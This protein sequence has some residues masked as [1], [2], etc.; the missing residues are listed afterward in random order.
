MRCVRAGVL[1]I[2]TVFASTALGCG[3][4]DGGT[5]NP[6]LRALQR[7]AK[8]DDAFGARFAVRGTSTE[9]GETIPI[10]GYGQIEA[11]EKRSRIVASGEGA[12]IEI[13]T[14]EPFAFLSLEGLPLSR[15]SRAE[16]PAGARWLKINQDTVADA[17]G[18]GGLRDLERLG[19]TEAIKLFAKLEPRIEKKALGQRVDGIK[20]TRYLVRMKLGRLF[21]AISERAEDAPELPDSQRDIEMGCAVWIDDDDLVRRVR[22]RLR[23][24]KKATVLTTEI[25]SYDRD[26]RVTIPADQTAYDVTDDVAKIARAEREKR[27]N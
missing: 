23:L 21:D 2:C 6:G 18:T 27:K 25:T 26:L 22:I 4:D 12:R 10:R 3:G 24:P 5:L 8:A 16:L 17:F 15:A 13:I 20:T 14:D 1:A 11:D 9:D 7:A 19:P